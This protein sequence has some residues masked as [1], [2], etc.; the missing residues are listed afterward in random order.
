MPMLENPALAEDR[1]VLLPGM[2]PGEYAIIN[3]DWRYIRY[4]DDTEELYNVRKDPNE[5]ENLADSMDHAETKKRL[6]EKLNR[7]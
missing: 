1:V 7:P 6:S 2:K 4:A 3:R 5:W